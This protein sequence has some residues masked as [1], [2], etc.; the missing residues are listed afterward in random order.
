MKKS[1]LKNVLILLG[2]VLI[3]NIVTAQKSGF[4]KYDNGNIRV[5]VLKNNLV[6]SK[7]AIQ[8]NILL[9][10]SLIPSESWLKKLDSK[11]FTPVT[12]ADFALNIMWT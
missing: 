8:D 7:V 2:I 11:G 4:S 5:F 3:S 10:D 12:D 6:N 1:I 9:S